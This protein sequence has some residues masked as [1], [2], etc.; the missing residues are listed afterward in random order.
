MTGWVSAGEGEAIYKRYCFACHDFGAAGAPKLDD[1]PAWAP[2]IA[3]GQETLLGSVVNGKGAMPPRGT[4]APCGDEDLK[5]A[6]GY[7]LDRAK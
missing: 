1:K 5:A 2:R 3:Q 4:C 7:M 6:V